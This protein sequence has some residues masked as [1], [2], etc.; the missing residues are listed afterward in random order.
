MSSE[1]AARPSRRTFLKGLGATAGVVS[2]SGCILPP[3]DVINGGGAPSLGGVPAS[4]GVGTGFAYQQPAIT[5]QDAH[6]VARTPNGLM[7]AIEQA[8]TDRHVIIWIPP[9]AV[10]NMTGQP[11]TTLRNVTLASSRHTN[12]IGGLIYT[13]TYGEGTSQYDGGGIFD[14]Q[15][16]SRVTGLRIRGPFSNVYNHPEYPGY[17]PKPNYG[18]RSRRYEYYDAH[19]ARGLTVSHGSVQVDNCELFGWSRM[20]VYVN[21]PRSYGVDQEQ[22]YPQFNNDAFHNNLMDSSGYG[23]EVI[24]GHAVIQRCYL[25]A[26]RHSIAG[27]GHPDSGFT[28]S[29]CF[30]DRII[31]SFPIDQH[32]MGENNGSGSSPSDYKYRY[33]GGGLMQVL[34]SS[35]AC[36]NV[37]EDSV[38]YSG[39]RQPALALQGVPLQKSV[40][41]GN[42]F[43]HDSPET[44]FSQGHT[45]GGHE[46]GPLGFVRW[47]VSGNQFGWDPHPEG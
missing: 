25:N 31:G 6:V 10:I 33:R 16:N 13:D 19:A 27:F 2:L 28:I 42:L 21:C 43:R 1:S 46:K 15:E 22:S 9:D 26:N 35:F 34:N 11:T 3:P 36:R 45:P 32:Y 14:M 12:H 44:A 38:V 29:E 41:K 40:V 17:L 7:S 4:G 24:R 23:I 20:A 37:F 5:G 30:Q 47:E 18:S 8:S 39:A